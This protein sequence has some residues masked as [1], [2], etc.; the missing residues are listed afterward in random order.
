MP[1]SCDSEDGNA[2]SVLITNLDQGEVLALCG[3]CFPSWVTATAQAI[4]ETADEDPGDTPAGPVQGSGPA[5]PSTDDD[6]LDV[7]IPFEL[8]PAAD[9]PAAPAKRKAAAVKP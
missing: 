9:V 7:P 4:A 3:A 6:D 5:G 2:A 1:Y 8:V